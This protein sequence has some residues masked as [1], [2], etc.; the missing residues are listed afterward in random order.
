MDHE[1]LRERLQPATG[2]IY[3]KARNA[4]EK[5]DQRNQRLVSRPRSGCK[6]PR[7]ALAARSKIY[8]KFT[9]PSHHPFSS[10]RSKRKH[11]ML[12]A[13]SALKSSWVRR[14]AWH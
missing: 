10:L 8:K 14:Q 4:P 11:S 6:K 3:K 13:I 5:P 12:A 1:F 2:S 7:R 9:P